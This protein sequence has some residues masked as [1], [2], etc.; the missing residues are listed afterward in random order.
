VV[1]PKVVFQRPFTRVFALFV[2]AVVAA[3]GA[4]VAVD[5]FGADVIRRVFAA[6]G[7]VFLIYWAP[8]SWR[9]L[10]SPTPTLRIDH[11]GIEG[12]FGFV[13]WVDVDRAVISHRYGRRP[14]IVRTVRLELKKG[15]PAPQ[16]STVEYAPSAITGKPSVTDKAI[17]LPLWSSRRAIAE[18]LQQYAPGLLG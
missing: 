17:V 5:G 10:R 12:S 9:L 11:E 3:G 4:F 8:S 1:P 13:K 18:D 7:V 2:Y 6:V 15:A 16:R 14:S